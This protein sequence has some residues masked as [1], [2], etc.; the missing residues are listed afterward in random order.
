MP[1][2]TISEELYAQLAAEAGDEDIEETMWKMVA[3]YRRGENPEAD[4]D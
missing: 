1:E 4:T 2:L 3:S